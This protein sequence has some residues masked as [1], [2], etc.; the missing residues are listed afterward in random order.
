M[1]ELRENYWYKTFY[2]FWSKLIITEIF[3]YVTIIVLN[4][5][6]IGKIV[7]ASSFRK[8]VSPERNWD[9]TSS[10]VFISLF[11]LKYIRTFLHVRMMKSPSYFLKPNTVV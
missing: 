9:I 11:G 10:R 5:I 8:Q 3:P 1:T 6:I 7:S 2:V 4:I